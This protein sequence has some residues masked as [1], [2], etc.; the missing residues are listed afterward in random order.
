MYYVANDV[1]R[2]Q[3]NKIVDRRQVVDG[4]RGSG[5]FSLSRMEMKRRRSHAGFIYRRAFTRAPGARI[6][7]MLNLSKRRVINGIVR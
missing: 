4:I 5:K 6:S 7:C 1:I 3:R 2:Y